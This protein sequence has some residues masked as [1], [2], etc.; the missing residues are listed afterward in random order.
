MTLEQMQIIFEG[1]FE[2]VIVCFALGYG[3]GM[4]IKVLKM[5]IDK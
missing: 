2:L 3:I 5:A 4:I 1:G